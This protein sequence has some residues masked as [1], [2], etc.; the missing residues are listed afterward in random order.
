M[1]LKSNFALNVVLNLCDLIQRF[2]RLWF[3]NTPSQAPQTVRNK[4]SL[5]FSHVLSGNPFFPL[6]A[7]FA[8]SPA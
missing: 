2:G 4:Y 7:V 5:S 1:F 8:E 6:I 3:D